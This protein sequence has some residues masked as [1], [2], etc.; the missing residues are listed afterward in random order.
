MRIMIFAVATLGLW[1][2]ASSMAQAQSSLPPIVREAIEASWKDCTESTVLKAES[3]SLEAGFVVERDVN[4]DGRKDYIL[5]YGKF[6]CGDTA[7]RIFCGSAGCLTQVFASQS[8]GTYTKVL[9]ENVRGFRFARVKGR[10]A[11]VLELHHSACD[12]PGVVPCSA[13]LFWNGDRFSP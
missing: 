10:P 6:R 9:D 13:T 2:L 4:G 5:D 1:S 12:R 3:V 7:G 11:M 8:D